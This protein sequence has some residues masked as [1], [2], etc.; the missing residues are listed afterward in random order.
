MEIYYTKEYQL[1]DYF[2]ELNGNKI[3]YVY[4]IENNKPVLLKEIESENENCSEDLIRIFLRD[5][6]SLDVSKIKVIEL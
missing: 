5:E 1:H 4:K 3:L 2:P 6:M